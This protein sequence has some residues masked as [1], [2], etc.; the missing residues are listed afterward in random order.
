[1]ARQYEDFKAIE[2]SFGAFL[3]Q[4]LARM[5]KIYR[6]KKEIDKTQ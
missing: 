6:Y 2:A 3:E 1:M 5:E 4:D